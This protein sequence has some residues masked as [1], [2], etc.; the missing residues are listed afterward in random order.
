MFM[1]MPGGIIG[2]HGATEGAARGG[3]WAVM[4]MALPR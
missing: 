3:S 4:V 2:Q 1:E